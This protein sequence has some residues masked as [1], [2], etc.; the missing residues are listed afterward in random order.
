VV[1]TPGFMA[2]EQILGMPLDGRA[3][4]YALG[5]VAWWLLTGR[6]VFPREGADAKML[7]KHIYE[8]I[9]SLREKMISWCPPELEAILKTMLAK[10][11][12]DRPRDARHLSSM[13]RAIPIPSEHAWTE[14]KAQEWWASYKPAAAVPSVSPSE[15]QVI[16]PVK[17]TPA[18]SHEVTISAAIKP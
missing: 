18:A 9:P 6:E 10:D 8:V 1:G 5:C 11:A 12:S 16:M 14:A 7:H 13:L 4:I 2:P 15:V 17:T 3:D